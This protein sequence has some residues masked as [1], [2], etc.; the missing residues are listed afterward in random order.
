MKFIINKQFLPKTYF[1]IKFLNRG[2]IDAG[3]NF[4]VMTRKRSSQRLELEDQVLE[5]VS[6]EKLDMNDYEEDSSE[7]DDVAKLYQCV[8]SVKFIFY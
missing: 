8:K 5:H 2:E 3:H 4:R 1:Q 6:D 7:G